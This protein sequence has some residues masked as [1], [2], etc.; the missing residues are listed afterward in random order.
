M[1]QWASDEAMLGSL[2]PA[3]A[4]AMAGRAVRA[5]NGQWV[6]DLPATPDIGR[7]FVVNSRIP[8]AATVLNRVPVAGK[9]VATIA[10]TH[11]RAAFTLEH[12]VYELSSIYPYYKP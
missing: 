6:V 1:S 12:G 4:E 9:T 8:K 5:D 3:R 11:V 7:V 2:G 10:P